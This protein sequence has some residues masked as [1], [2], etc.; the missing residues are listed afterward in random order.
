MSKSVGVLSVL[1]SCSQ[2]DE[3]F[4]SYKSA[5]DSAGYE[6]T[7]DEEEDDAEVNFS[8]GSPTSQVKM[9]QRCKDRTGLTIT[10]RPQ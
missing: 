3:A 10:I 2:L 5:F 6:V 9:I 8:G 7:K 1:S 4:D